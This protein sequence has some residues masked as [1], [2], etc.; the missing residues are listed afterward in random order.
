MRTR[1]SIYTGLLLGVCASALAAG[2]QPAGSEASTG[3]ERLKESVRVTLDTNAPPAA[4]AETNIQKRFSVQAAWR[5]WEGLHLELNRRTRLP[6]LAG[7]VTQFLVPSNALPPICL[8]QVQMTL[9]LGARLE[10]DTAAFLTSGY[11]PDMADD[12]EVRRALFTASGDCILVFP[13]SYEIQLGYRPNSFYLNK[14][15]LASEDLN[16]IGRLQAGVFCPPMGLDLITS[17]RDITFMEPAAPLQA[18]GPPN[19]TGIQIG[20]PVLHQRATW[21]F[22]IFGD[23]ATDVEY[24]NASRNYGSAMGRLTWLALDHLDPDHPSANRFLHLGLSAN[25]QYS[26]T[27][28]IQYR[29]RP[30]SYIAPIVID[31]GVIDAS[32]AV[33][34]AGE[35]AWVD[36]PL[37]VQGEFIHA[38]VQGTNTLNFWGFY[39]QASWFLTGESRPYNPASGAFSRLVPL[40]NFNLGRGGAWGAVELAARFSHT[41]LDDNYVQGGRLNLFMAGVNW[42]LNPNVRCMF[43]CGVGRV[44]GGDWNGH[45]LIAQTRIGV[46]F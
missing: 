8:D 20:H 3:P 16:Y 6:N 25:F 19:E 23:A 2:T 36:G 17:S 41:D 34:A 7:P 18:I 9:N 37:A 33:T 44:Y 45:M 26:V 22:G 42:Y 35:A 13:V 43:N 11:V 30:E 4:A 14:S 29:S 38:T 32:K 21:A 10:V 28:D 27:S 1:C 46:D 15:Y 39:A 31:T 5:G 12:V 24:G 40:R